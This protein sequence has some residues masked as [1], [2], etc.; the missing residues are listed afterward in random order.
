MSPADDPNLEEILRLVAKLRPRIV[1]LFLDLRLSD[2]EVKERVKD[3][4]R[5]LAWRWNRVGDRER[6]LLLKLGG[7]APKLSITSEKEPEA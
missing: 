5:E 7:D 1:R 2:E 4:L 6:W 3:A